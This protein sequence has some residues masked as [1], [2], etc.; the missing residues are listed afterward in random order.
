MPLDK[1][2]NYAQIIEINPT[3]YKLTICYSYYSLY[4]FKNVFVYKTL[5]ECINKLCLE[6]CNN[7]IEILKANK[8]E[9]KLIVGD[10]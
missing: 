8:D 3:A 6:R 4:N 7:K 10:G 5:E 1:K 2:F 9:I